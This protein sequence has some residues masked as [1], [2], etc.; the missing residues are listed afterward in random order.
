MERPQNI[1]VKKNG[2]ATEYTGK[3]NGEATEYTGKREWR[4]GRIYR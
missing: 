1:Q 2:E 3:K 4:G